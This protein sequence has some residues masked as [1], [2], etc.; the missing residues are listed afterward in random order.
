MNPIVTKPCD[1]VALASI[2]TIEL[3]SLI[4]SAKIDFVTL[5]GVYGATPQGL[6]GLPKRPGKYYGRRLTLHDPTQRDLEK[7]HAAFPNASLAEIEVSVDVAPRAHMEKDDRSAFLAAVK[8]QLFARRLKPELLADLTSDFRGTYIPRPD[9]FSLAPFNHRIPA[10]NEQ[11]LHGTKYDDLQVKVY[12][13]VRDNRKALDWRRHVVRVEVRLKSKALIHHRLEKVGDL[14]G[15]PLRK[16][17]MPHFRHVRGTIRPSARK[18]SPV[19]RLLQVL[20]QRQQ[21]YDDEHWQAFGVGAFLRGGKRVDT[22]VAFLRDQE[23]NGRIGQA[24]HRLQ[25]RLSKKK[26]VRDKVSRTDENSVAMR[27]SA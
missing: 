1:T 13:K 8:T 23:L 6:D 4:F 17:L 20:N 7:L 9:G 27:V 5:D 12:V 26:F 14:F 21:Q 24:L 2:S 3:D 16:E 15:Y 10:S 11:H 18:R 19:R 22:D 25:K